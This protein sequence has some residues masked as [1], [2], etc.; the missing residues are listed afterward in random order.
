MQLT[1]GP[2]T[3]AHMPLPACMLTGDFVRQAVRA[4]QPQVSKRACT[5][6]CAAHCNCSVPCGPHSL[7]L[8]QCCDAA[9]GCR[10][11][12]QH[13]ADGVGR[14]GH[15]EAGAQT[16]ELRLQRRHLK[17]TAIMSKRVLVVHARSPAHCSRCSGRQSTTSNAKCWLDVASDGC[18]PNCAKSQAGY[19]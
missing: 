16:V 5:A 10:S 11:C 2:A 3:P 9:V 4:R 14:R 17:G 7:C 15:H 6:P 13:H 8:Y 18:C 1:N 12:E 19:S